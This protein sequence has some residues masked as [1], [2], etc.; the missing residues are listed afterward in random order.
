MFDLFKSQ[1][2][3]ER[4]GVRDVV[5][6]AILK[7]E[8][9]ARTEIHLLETAVEP[10]LRSK[11]IA[12]LLDV[13]F[14]CERSEKEV[15]VWQARAESLKARGQLHDALGMSLGTRLVACGVLLLH[16]EGREWR[17]ASLPFARLESLLSGLVSRYGADV[18]PVAYVDHLE[19]DKYR[20]ALP[21]RRGDDEGTLSSQSETSTMAF[22]STAMPPDY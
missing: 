4:E 10:P 8:A 6:E 22:V 13:L 15:A 2:R 3:L 17:D 21:P 20:L 14:K 11:A 7:S 9:A 19:F 12:R 18:W 1:A 16:L 5:I